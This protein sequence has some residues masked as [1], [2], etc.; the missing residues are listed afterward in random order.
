MAK[1]KLTTVWTEIDERR[2]ET[3]EQEVRGLVAVPVPRRAAPAHR[4]HAVDDLRQAASARG[5]AASRGRGSGRRTRRGARRWRR[6]RRRRR[7]RRAGCGTAARGPSCSGTGR[8]SRRARGGPGG[9]A[10]KRPAQATAKSVIAS[11]NRLIEVRHFCRRSSRMAEMSVPACPIPIHQTKLMIVEAPADRDVDC[12]RSRRPR[13]KRYAIAPRSTIVSRNEMREPE[14]HQTGGVRRERTIGA[15]LVGDRGEGVPRL[16]HG[17][18]AAGGAP[19][20][21]RSFLT[22]LAPRPPSPF[23]RRGPASGSSG[24]GCAPRRGRSSAAACPSSPRRP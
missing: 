22:R 3:R 20:P 2:R 12:P 16:D 9:G 5:R 24:S 8:A 1:S 10:G 21:G 15:D 11:A 7:P 18:P 17:R 13:A 6:S 4:Q 23:A 14:Y 19:E